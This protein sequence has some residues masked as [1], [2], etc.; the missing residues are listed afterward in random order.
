MNNEKILK[1]KIEKY[2]VRPLITSLLLL[3]MC[4]VLY[5]YD[6]KAGLIAGAFVVAV[7]I[8]QLVIFYIT[9]LGVMPSLM[10]FALEQ[11]QIQKE[12][13]K[14]LAIPYALLD[15]DGKIMW[16]NDGFVEAIGDGSRKRI[17]KN[18]SAVFPE[19]GSQ[20]LSNEQ[21]F[22]MNLEYNDI[23]YSA[24]IKK[25]KFDEVFE[26]SDEMVNTKGESLIA[27]Y[28]FDVTELN[29][30]K[31]ENEEQ[32]LVA[33][34]LYIDNYDEVME[35]TEE[36]RHSLVEALVDRRINMYGQYRCN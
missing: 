20:A 27:M 1:N 13:L 16:A 33:G 35:N 10:A 28:L 30:Y 8:V 24:L 18:I 31:R 26:D 6:K 29:H 32:K 2:L 14:E 7:L 21:Q 9:K 17:R 11:G 25:I 3:V 22:N 19:L 34:L 4:G 12:L 23:Q 15:T 5:V 36:V